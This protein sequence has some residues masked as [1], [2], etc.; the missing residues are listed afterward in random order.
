MHFQF[1]WK[2]AWSWTRIYNKLT[3]WTTDIVCLAT[4]KVLYKFIFFTHNTKNTISAIKTNDCTA[5]RWRQ[6]L[7]KLSYHK[8]NSLI[9]HWHT[10]WRQYWCNICAFCFAQ[11]AIRLC[12]VCFCLKLMQFWLRAEATQSITITNNWIVFHLS[13]N[14]LIVCCLVIVTIH[15]LLLRAQSSIK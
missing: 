6:E 9:T 8:F 7:S 14:F 11:Y 3:Y 10:N 15:Y 5:A 13:L 12:D 2:T 1:L 4:C